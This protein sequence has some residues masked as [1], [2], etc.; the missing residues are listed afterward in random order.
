MIALWLETTLPAILSQYS[1]QDIFNADEFGMF[2][3]CVPNK[4][5]DFKNEK[6]PGGNH[7]KIRLTG[8]AT[9]NVNGERLPMFVIGKS[10]TPRCFNGEKNVPCHNRVPPKSWISSELFEEWVKEIDGNLGAQKRKIALIID[11]CHPD[12]PALHWMELIFL[13]PNTTPIAQVMDQGVIRS[14]NAK[15]C[16]LAVKKHIDALEKGNQLPAFS[17]LTATSC[18]RKYGITFETIHSRIVSKSQGF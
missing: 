9:G 10:K 8:M 3:Q 12:V 1:L 6:C 2:F 17:I 11:N 5:Y 4:T 13:P 18:S 15:Y 14:L 16:S 7:T